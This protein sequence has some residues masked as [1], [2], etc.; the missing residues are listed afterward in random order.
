MSKI[1]IDPYHRRRAQ[2][3][4]DF[5]YDKGF[6]ADDLTRESMRWLEDY[7]AFI[8]QSQ[9]EMSVKGALLTKQIREPVAKKEG[10]GD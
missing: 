4:T 7:L 9:C 8:I 5:L 6:L 2:E 1:E 10:D 3:L